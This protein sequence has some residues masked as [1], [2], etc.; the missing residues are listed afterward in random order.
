M[1]LGPLFTALVLLLGS[2]TLAAS[3]TRHVALIFDD[4]PHAEQTP[5]LLAIFA[6][7]KI[8][9]TFGTVG[10]AAEANPALLQH[11]VAAGHEVANHSYSHQQPKNLT[12]EQVDAEVRDGQAKIIAAAS[13]A[14]VWYWPP[15]IAIDDH[16]RASVAKA[17]LRIYF[18]KKLV[19]SGDYMNEVDA[20]EIL[21]RATTGIEDG[22]VILFHEWRPETAAQ[23]KAVVAE[24]RKQGCVFL[25][26]SEL[27]RYLGQ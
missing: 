8:H 5:K 9:V 22:T 14:P 10:K 27:A 19:A 25:T 7:E 18:P 4:G 21:R 23:M 1:N 3:E 17:G 6:E 26:F 13:V 15:Y 24:L 2:T 11:V 16:V 12:A 20:A